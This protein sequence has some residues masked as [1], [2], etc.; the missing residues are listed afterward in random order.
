MRKKLNL[1]QGKKG[2]KSPENKRK[3]RST[4]VGMSSRNK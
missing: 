2:K 1:K 4:I 3:K